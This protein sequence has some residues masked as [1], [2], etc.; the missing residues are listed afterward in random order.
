MPD[1]QRSASA[2]LL[3]DEVAELLQRLFPLMRSI[4]G[5]GVRETHRILGEVA[6]L[7]RIEIP[8]GTPVLDWTVPKE[9]VFRAAYVAGPDGRRVID[10]AA[11]NLHLVNY[12]APFRG[13]LSRQA[14][15]AH[16]HSLPEMPGA[17]PYVTS[18]YREDWGF[19]VSQ[20]QRDSL[21]EGDYEVVVDCDL[22]DGAMTLSEAV[23]PGETQDEVFFSCYTCHPSLAN[24]ELCAPVALA[25]LLRRLAREP[26][27]RLTYRFV[28]L[29]E[30]IGSIAYLSL[31]GEHLKRHMAAGV[32]LAD[33]GLPRPYR[34]KRSRRG[35]SLADRAATHLLPRRALA[36]GESPPQIVPFAPVGSD[37][38]Q[39]CSPGFDL[40]VVALTRGEA[41]Y[42]EYHTSLDDLALVSPET[43]ART[44]EDLAALCA[45]LDRN[46]RYRN[47]KP[48]GEPQLG[49]YGLY[50]SKGSRNDR[51]Q[52]VV[53][54]LWAL[55]QADGAHDLLATAEKSDLPFDLVAE[56]AEAAAAKGLLAEITDG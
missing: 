4:T 49:R 19:C 22:V 27:R 34:I 39:Y 33:I 44:V 35:D 47:L 14:L 38:R 21:P 54:L 37:E 25:L 28:F 42:P 55:N 56:M 23:L 26:R 51:N 2:G 6:P 24:D 12:S 32:A 45:L 15:D 13:R 31:R 30:T 7:E 11:H 29:P 40:P 9:W 41:A 3:A 48:H 36:D 52:Q 10:A 8:S 18:Y 5:A 20:R 16:L 17:I 53:A 1:M 50:P 43:V 46:R